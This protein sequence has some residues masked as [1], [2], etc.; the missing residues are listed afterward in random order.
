MLYCGVMSKKTLQFREWASVVGGLFFFAIH[1]ILTL[2]AIN[3][4]ELSWQEVT[5]AL[6]A[7]LLLDGIVFGVAWLFFRDAFK[8]SL[9]T[10]L[11][12]LLFFSFGDLS[13][14]LQT[15]FGLGFAKADFAVLGLMMALLLWL[16]F[17]LWR[18]RK[19][20]QIWQTWAMLLGLGFF[21]Q[22]AY[23]LGMSGYREGIFASATMGMKPVV[24][25]NGDENLP[26]IYYI[27]L[28]GY[29]RSDILSTYYG[30]DNSDF[31]ANLNEMGFYIAEE[32]NSNYIQTLLSVG[33][34]LNMD[35]ISALD[36]E[37]EAIENRQDLITL[38]QYSE[39]RRI[40]A[41]KGYRT[42]SFKNQ[43]KATIPDA[44]IF[45]DDN[46]ENLF[47]P[48]SQF[49]SIVMEHSLLRVLSHWKAARAVLGEMPY[50]VHRDEI[51][52][53]FAH[54]QEIPALEGNYFVYAHIIS[55]HPPFIFDEHGNFSARREAF[56]LFDANYYIKTHSEKDYI[57]SYGRQIQY[58]NSLVLETVDEIIAE[59]STL[60]IIILQGDHGPGA[61][62][63]WGSLEN[64][65]IPEERFGILN[66]YY[67]PK[68]DEGMLYSSLSPVNSFRIVLNLLFDKNYPLLEERHYY[69]PWMYPFSWTEVVLE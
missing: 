55:P 67:I 20:A 12:L 59:S 41:E 51:L 34:S 49:E 46:S 39:V 66:A 23:Q 1:P 24:A 6:W 40:L 63:H 14:L 5:R 18:E 54:L 37:G 7:A 4:G 10:S 47:S 30:V 48:V 11:F 2:F 53:T 27:I 8:A 35:Y 62:L 28:D 69:S 19:Q 50:K 26:D 25:A 43:Y 60:P 16:A 13:D 56:S 36:V 64:T 29:G 9:W 3:A 65:S 33:S 21:V 17:V 32:S 61:F 15:Q 38:V 44:E 57:E 31:L 22:A 42:I 52:S 68:N 58:I 45:F